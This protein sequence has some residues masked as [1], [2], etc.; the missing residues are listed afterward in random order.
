[1]LYETL[2][3]KIPITKGWSCDE[4]FCVTTAEGNKYL[5]R[6]TPHEKSAM[7]KALFE[8]LQDVAKLGIPMCKPVEFGRCNDG[9]YTLHTWID[10]QDAEAVIPLLP[11]TE[12]YAFGFKAGEI[13][14]KIHSIPAPH[15]Q[16]DWYT[17]FN[18][19][20]DWKIQKYCACGIR[21]RGDDTII[22]YLKNNRGV[23]KDRPQCFQHGDYHIGNMMFENNNLVIIDFDRFDFGDPWEE[24]NRIVWCA[25]IAP[26]FAAGM[27]DGYF[28]KNVPMEF[29]RCLAFY[30]GSNTLSS[31]YWAIGFGKSDINVM[32]KQSQDV[33]LWYNNLQDI[34]PS[35]Y[36]HNRLL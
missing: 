4:K 8:I 27:V 31:I 33:L 15:E 19:K 10:G 6:I 17:R 24:F 20:T 28:N 16:E 2:T 30:I 7:R 34:I 22:E 29:W 9:V 13:L 23:L 21:F 14:K 35:W 32:M 25:Q 26:Y 5:L 18:R 1:M 11:E 36:R 3:S 12:Q